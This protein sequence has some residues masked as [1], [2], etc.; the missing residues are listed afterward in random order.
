MPVQLDKV[1]GF[2]DRARSTIEKRCGA[3]GET[4]GEYVFIIEYRVVQ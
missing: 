1:S 2:E 4:T 3:F